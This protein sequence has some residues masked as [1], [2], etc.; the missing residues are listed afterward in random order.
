MKRLNVI[1]EKSEEAHSLEKRRMFLR[2]KKF[3]FKERILQYGTENIELAVKQSQSMPY[4][5]MHLTEKWDESWREQSN[6]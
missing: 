6:P 5:A 4:Q 3:Y 1:F 2:L